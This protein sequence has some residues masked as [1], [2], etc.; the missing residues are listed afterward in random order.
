VLAF[1]NEVR[2]S[3]FA[4]PLS[5]DPYLARRCKEHAAI[6]IAAFAKGEQRIPNDD[7]RGPS[8]ES[9]GGSA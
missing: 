8:G 7:R 9:V 1:V 6:A 2:S 5:W 4:V 3:H